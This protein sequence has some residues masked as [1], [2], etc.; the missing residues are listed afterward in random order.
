MEVINLTDFQV[1]HV[2][3]SDRYLKID[4]A[5]GNTIRYRCFQDLVKTMLVEE[6]TEEYKKDK[7]ALNQFL[8]LLYLGEIRFCKEKAKTVPVLLAIAAE[9]MSRHEHFAYFT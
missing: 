8:S 6:I 2:D 3:I 1:N 5:F 9:V 7:T 4:Y